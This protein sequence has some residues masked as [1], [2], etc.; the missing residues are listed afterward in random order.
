[1]NNVWSL[2]GTSAPGGTRYNNFLLQPFLTYNFKGGWFFGSS[3]IATANWLV[4]GDKAW[5]LPV[6]AQFGR[7]IQ[8]WQNSG[9]PPPWR[10]L[11]HVASAIWLDLADQITDRLRLLIGAGTEGRVGMPIKSGAGM[12]CG[13]VQ[14]GK[15][16]DARNCWGQRRKRQEPLAT[17]PV[18]SNALR[19]DP[20]GRGPGAMRSQLSAVHRVEHS[21]GLQGSSSGWSVRR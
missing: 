12:P 9:E 7:V 16:H 8:D 3:P 5:T 14:T 2:G 13:R 20:I 6:G 11:Q 21:V 1:M 4:S 15:E 10:I 18:D 17:G 19:R